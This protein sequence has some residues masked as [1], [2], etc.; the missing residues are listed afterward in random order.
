MELFSKV[1]SIISQN[2]NR[3]EAIKPTDRLKEDLDIDSFDGL[4]IV[5]D[6]EDE[7][8]ISIEP[9]ELKTLKVVQDIVDRL[10]VKIRSVKTV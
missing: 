9:E 8:G 4:M 7:F 10:E 5:N 2:K 6:L 1:A 3:T